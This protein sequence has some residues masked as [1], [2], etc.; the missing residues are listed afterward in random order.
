[1]DAETTEE[2]RQAGN[3]QNIVNQHRILLERRTGNQDGKKKSIR[4]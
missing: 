3:L 1:M 2:I 4:I